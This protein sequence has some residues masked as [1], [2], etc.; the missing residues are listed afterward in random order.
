MR[1]GGEERLDLQEK[2]IKRILERSLPYLQDAID[3]IEKVE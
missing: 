1:G 3:P 2:G